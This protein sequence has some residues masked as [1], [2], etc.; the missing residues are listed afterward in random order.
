LI[1]QKG[2]TMFISTRWYSSVQ[3]AVLEMN[4]L[5]KDYEIAEFQ[6]LSEPN[7][8][9]DSGTYYCIVAVLFK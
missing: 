7:Q 9:S 4:E 5:A 2:M 8:N 6:V 3:A 1:R